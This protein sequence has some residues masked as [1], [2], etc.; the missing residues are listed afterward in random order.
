MLLSGATTFAGSFTADF[1]NP[2]TPGYYLNQITDT[3]N[4]S[5]P[6]LANA[7][8]LLLPNEA[9][10]GPVL[11]VV[12]D[13]DNGKAIDSFTAN[14]QLQIG[15]GTSNP[16]DGLSFAFGPD[17]SE[18]STFAEEG[19][20]MASGGVCVCFDTYNN[21]APDHIGLDVKVMGDGTTTGGIV[22]GGI[23]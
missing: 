6:V 15:P 2:N 19:P 20:A 12:N 8:L 4:N 3:A 5:Y 23:R 13:L 22:P 9:S 11:I 1:T 7:Q 14:F 10:V 21:G 17:I 18:F 16:A